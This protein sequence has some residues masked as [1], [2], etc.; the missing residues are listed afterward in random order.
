MVYS[1]ERVII[2][3][4]VSHNRLMLDEKI[5]I[6]VVCLALANRGLTFAVFLGLKYEESSTLTAGVGGGGRSLMVVSIY[7]RSRWWR[8]GVAGQEGN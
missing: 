5:F 6:Y 4:K 2:I 7:L 1:S 8:D 3:R